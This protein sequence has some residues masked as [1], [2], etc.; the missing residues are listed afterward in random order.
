[1]ANNP[2]SN[3]NSPTGKQDLSPEELRIGPPRFFEV[4]LMQ[5]S[6]AKPSALC[7]RLRDVI[8]ANT[9]QRNHAINGRGAGSPPAQSGSSEGSI[10]SGCSGR[11]GGGTSGFLAVMPRNNTETR[12]SAYGRGTR[13]GTT[14]SAQRV[15]T[16][17]GI[18][19]RLGLQVP[20]SNS[21][22]PPTR[23]SAAGVA[24][25]RGRAAP[26]AP[27]APTSTAIRQGA[28]GA[29]VKKPYKRKRQSKKAPI[30]TYFVSPKDFCALV[31]KL[32][33][34]EVVPSPSS[35]AAPNPAPRSAPAMVVFSPQPEG[36]RPELEKAN[37]A[38]VQPIDVEEEEANEVVQPVDVDP[39]TTSSLPEDSLKVPMTSAAAGPPS[40]S[41]IVTVTNPV[42]DPPSP[43][44]SPG[45]SSL[46]YCMGFVKF[47]FPCEFL[48]QQQKDHDAKYDESS[49][50]L[51]GDDGLPPLYEKPM[52]YEKRPHDEGASS[53][54]ASTS[55]EVA[56]ELTNMTD[57]VPRESGTFSSMSAEPYMRPSSHRHRQGLDDLDYQFEYEP[58]LRWI[59]IFANVSLKHGKPRDTMVQT[60][61][62]ETRAQHLRK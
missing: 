54:R 62:L 5:P 56:S 3:P 16:S 14:H 34:F 36:P 9:F 49:G 51:P 50:Q 57:G 58:R 47:P 41:P 43:P 27:S 52:Q 13:N 2:N 46:N 12:P 48:E 32:T 11:G 55:R 6:S 40:P 45:S 24:A 18:A 60:G 42:A 59:D 39:D 26:S 28:A 33:G 25:G 7:F 22:M 30:T 37:E 10:S 29:P 38:M 53:A 44:A 23:S 31:Q 4:R 21:T 17:R 35:I 8:N 15:T 61:I 20:N 1:M 19:Q